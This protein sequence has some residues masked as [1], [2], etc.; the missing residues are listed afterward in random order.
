MCTCIALLLAAGLSADVF[1]A[2]DGD[3][4]GQGTLT[5]P[6]RTIQRGVSDLRPG[7]TCTVRAGTYR[8]RVVL[9][10]S[11][12]EGRPIRIR[13]Y[14]GELVILD[15]TEAVV[16]PWEAYR[17]SI[18]RTR[19]PLA[20]EQLFVD[21]EMI[22]EARWPN[23]AFERQFSR[24]GWATTGPGSAYQFVHDPELAATGIDWTGAL[25]ILNV[26]HQFWTW[27]RPVLNHR[28]GGETFEYRIAM[29]PFHSER[30]GW[31]SD[32]FYYLCGR[33]EALD[34]PGEWFQHVD[35]RLYLWTL[36]GRDPG[37]R[38]VGV[39]QRHEGFAGNGLRHVVLSG[40]HFFACCFD[41]QQ[42][43]HCVVESCHLLFP[44][45]ERG[46]PDAEEP[47]R[48]AHGTRISGTDNRVRGCSL[49][50]SGNWGIRVSG[51]RNVVENCLIHDVNWTGT[52]RHTGIALSGLGQEERSENTARFC[53]VYNVGNT[54]VQSGNNRH[55]VVEYCH[56]HHGGMISKD[57]SLIYT[58]MPAATGSEFRYNWV[59]D[60]LSPAHSLGIRGDDKTR[61]MRVHHNVVWNCANDG[62]VAKGGLNQVYNNTCLWNGACDIHFNSGREPDKWWQEHVPAYERQN[63]DSLLVNNCAAAIVSTRR[64]V[65]PGIPGDHSH[66]YRG[67]APALVDPEHLDFRPRAD[68]PLVDAGRAV[69]GVTAPFVGRS[70]DI[71][72]YE[73]GGE[74]WLPGHRNGVC[75]TRGAGG[76]QV[77]LN[78]PVSRATVLSVR[79]GGRL[80]E[81]P[82]GPAD[83]MLPQ[84]LSA[85]GVPAGP[86][87]FRVSDWGEA[88]LQETA[89]IAAGSE[90]R[91]SFPKPDLSCTP[92]AAPS[93]HYAKAYQRP[94]DMLPAFRAW[95]I[96]RAVQMD[97]AMAAGEWAPAWEPGRTLRLGSLHAEAAARGAAAGEA[98][99]QFDAEALYVAVRI[100][101]P[102]GELLGEGGTWGPDGSD[103]VEVDVCPVQAGR[104]GPVFVLHGYPSGTFES[105]SV[106]GASE[107]EAAR[108][109]AG[110]V[111]AARVSGDGTWACEFRIPFAAMGVEQSKLDHL[112]ANV[113][114]RRNGADGGPWFAAVRTGGANYE[115]ESAAV[116][117]LDPRFRADS[118]N[119]VQNGG[120]EREDLTPWTLG[121]NG[122][123][124]LPKESLQRLQAGPD[125][126]W[127]MVLRADDGEAM[128]ER[129][130]KWTHP[131]VGLGAGGAYC[132]SYD[133]RTEN[134]EPRGT[135]GSFNS[136]V[137]TARNAGQAES[138]L[139]S[140]NMPWQRRDLVIELHEDETPLLLSLQLHR[141]T[142]RVY[143][144]NVVL[145]RARR[146]AA[147]DGP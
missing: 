129:V 22:L 107:P 72:A 142:G 44:S 93:F 99:L 74:H 60:S 120:F 82:F 11:G 86:L 2:P 143:L 108:L 21:R 73:F 111:F 5:A 23:T 19:C 67:S 106:A 113:G 66:N 134:L 56:I 1:V 4:R 51:L 84:A 104:R 25:A 16:G 30:K 8:E 126:T 96:D 100:T 102:G 80:R 109:A 146:P 42:I 6:F 34:A 79:W 147:K 35:G 14:P 29:N 139:T 47:P 33:L 55:G 122:G 59:H 103:G 105:V 78:L 28:T 133:I 70:P 26:A 75:V 18:Y 17:G 89:G 3:D 117:Y 132:L 62:I 141:A 61:G 31:W 95:W 63:E 116:L 38:E 36:D 101:A 13:A 58:S 124:A 43:E 144:D 7:D 9:S 115:V 138:I 81:L 131:L 40:F 46:I 53:T 65:D 50:Y 87:V 145:V 52:L 128:Q 121:S 41:L 85:E 12:E 20:V 27:S 39:K 83:W 49:A 15:G 91:L 88:L 64:A 90:A 68:S 140:R 136:Y 125:G 114:T 98:C 77:A 94:T 112:L 127:C 119:L 110:V 137:R 24:E 69:E 118:P 45:Y 130:I 10:C 37:L 48:L 54:I 71:G 97:G 32:D 57:I 92:D 76:L 135:M 123:E